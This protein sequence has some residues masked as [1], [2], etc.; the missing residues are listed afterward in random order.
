[1]KHENRI[2]VVKTILDNYV[3]DRLSTKQKH[4]VAIKCE[5][6]MCARKF[7]T[8]NAHVDDLESAITSC[9]EAY[10]YDQH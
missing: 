9:L 7:T 2:R 5:V 4:E 3:G 8:L 10:N 1:M 6:L